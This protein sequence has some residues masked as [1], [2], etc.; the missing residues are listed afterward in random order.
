MLA[1]RVLQNHRLSCNGFLSTAWSHSSSA[2]RPSPNAAIVELL[3]REKLEEERAQSP[4]SFKINAFHKAIEV[5]AHLPKPIQ[6][7]DDHILETKG[8]GIGIK[9]RI[10]EYF[11]RH[12]LE[13]AQTSDDRE[14]A[15]KRRA[16]IELQRVPG[17]GAVKAKALAQAG[18]MSLLD[19]VS[20]QEY[21]DK[22]S[23]LQITGLKYMG[24][25]AH[26]AT[27]EHVE[28]VIRLCENNLSSRYEFI[29]VGEYR[30][31]LT[32]CSS[33]EI[34][35][36]HPD[37]VHIPVPT[38]PPPLWEDEFDLDIDPPALPKKKRNTK[39]SSSATSSGALTKK[40][41]ESIILHREV[42]PVLQQRGV[43]CEKLSETRQ[44]WTGVVRLPSA[45]SSGTVPSGSSRMR[46][47]ELHLQ[48]GDYR[49]ITVHLVPQKS[50]AAGL[51]Q[52]TGDDG[53]LRDL[54]TSAEK[55]GRH[56]DEFGVWKWIRRTPVASPSEAPSLEV[57]P[58][59][60]SELSEDTSSPP[61]PPPPPPTFSGGSG[62][63][64]LV[65][66]ETEEDI[67]EE[68]GHPFVEPAKRN[69]DFISAAKSKSKKTIFSGQL[70]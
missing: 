7:G 60:T 63:W 59:P 46:A 26:A 4:N 42:I 16:V 18:C 45:P 19:L 56:L 57:T 68:L 22:L 21:L 58:S 11:V 29:P 39:A 34:M 43:L 53:L 25:L 6:S 44:T 65:K 13:V 52:F 33:I 3:R 61:P 70:R 40:D 51:L 35:V 67:F 38:A 50:R 17:I 32:E 24:H 69:F 12:D 28:Q 37:H 27:R 41:R 2:R 23:T 54:K 20:K 64:S 55:L 48:P 14:D 9:N 62:Y 31:G 10:N 30:R 66:T 5:I 1:R 15:L 36:L 47:S 49:R 8:I